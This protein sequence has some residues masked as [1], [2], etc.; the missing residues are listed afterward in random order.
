MQQFLR[1]RAWHI[2]H[3]SLRAVVVFGLRQPLL[4]RR[5]RRGGQRHHLRLRELVELRQWLWN[6]LRQQQLQWLQ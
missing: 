6:Q 3:L 5:L 2:D 1:Q 4:L